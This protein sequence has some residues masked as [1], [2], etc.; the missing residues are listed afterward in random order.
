MVSILFGKP[1]IDLAAISI[2]PYSDAN[3]LKF[4]IAKV[5]SHG[6]N[7]IVLADSDEQGARIERWCSHENVR[8][9]AT[10][11]FSD[12]KDGDRS[13]EDVIGTAAYVSALNDFYKTFG[14][15][16]PISVDQVHQEI[17]GRSLGKYL[18]DCF[19][20]RFDR[21]LD[22][23]GVAIHIAQGISELPQDALSRLQELVE[24]A[25]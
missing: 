15:F 25:R 21:R 16:V 6:G 18:Q 24:S 13:I 5:R 12:R 10:G 2:I 3:V 14:W 20:E 4:L 17:A 11:T 22:K 9:L 19:E 8:Y 23:I 1:H 7:A